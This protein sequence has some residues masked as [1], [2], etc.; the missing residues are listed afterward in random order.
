MYFVSIFFQVTDNIYLINFILDMQSMYLK[1]VKNPVPGSRYK[2]QFNTG[3][4]RHE[5]IYSQAPEESQ[6]FSEYEED[7][8]CVGSNEEGIAH[9]TG[10]IAHLK[11]H[12]NGLFRE[13]PCELER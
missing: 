11:I 13:V 7:S 1:S 10:T 5:D 8:F 2:L 6:G 12:C 4:Q 9:V 3:G